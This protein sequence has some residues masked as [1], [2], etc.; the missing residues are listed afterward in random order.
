MN[1]KGFEKKLSWLSKRYYHWTCLGALEK[2]HKNLSQDSQFQDRCLNP[3]PA[4]YE[5][6]H[7]RPRGSVIIII[8]IIIIII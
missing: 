1:L 6:L 4:E 2:P 5:V 3:G 7:T 8:I